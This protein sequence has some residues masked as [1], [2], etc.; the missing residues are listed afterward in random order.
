MEEASIWGDG[1]DE[2]YSEF[3]EANK[4]Y[5]EAV[6]DYRNSPTPEN[7]EIMEKAEANKRNKQLEGFKE[8]A[9]SLNIDPSFLDN[10]D[11]EKPWTESEQS[12]GNHEEVL[13]MNDFVEKVSGKFSELEN[14]LKF[15]EY[16]AE[17]GPEIK[18]AIDPNTKEIKWTEELKEKTDSWYEKNLKDKLTKENFWK[19]LKMVAIAFAVFGAYE[20]AMMF[21]GMLCDMAKA[22][23]GCYWYSNDG[24]TIDQVQFNS[25]APVSPN[26]F[27]YDTC[28]GGCDKGSVQ[29][30]CAGNPEKCCNSTIDVQSEKHKDGKYSYK[31]VSLGEEL[32]NALKIPAKLFNPDTIK[33]YLMIFVYIIAGILGAY[34]LFALIRYFAEK[35]EK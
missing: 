32:L 29:T 24:Q 7:K 1:F 30:I 10:I 8:V 3:E 25:R 18:E 34:I 33:K 35:G 5:D 2:N 11:L 6:I 23:S 20:L 13:S 4:A 21:K 22:S 31:C 15:K 16:F 19:F 9:T 26:C 14:T 28:C 27:S 12:F 17:F